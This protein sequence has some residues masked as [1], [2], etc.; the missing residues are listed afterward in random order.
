[1]SANIATTKGERKARVIVRENKFLVSDS[2]VH[3]P[4]LYSV[5]MK[6]LLS[7]VTL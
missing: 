1:M 2:H 7:K 5:H 4:S 6:V 3:S